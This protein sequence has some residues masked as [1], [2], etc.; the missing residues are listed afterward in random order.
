MPSRITIYYILLLVKL[1]IYILQYFIYYNKRIFLTIP[2]FTS[3]Y[4]ATRF[5][6][7]TSRMR[8]RYLCT[9]RLVNLATLFGHASKEKTIC[10]PPESNPFPNNPNGSCHHVK[11]RCVRNVTTVKAIWLRWASVCNV[12]YIIDRHTLTAGISSCVSYC[13][14]DC[15]PDT[16]VDGI[17]NS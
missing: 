15:G 2:Y 10:L 1:V 8:P 17:I 6:R 3:E 13:N 5:N 4:L 9:V 14:G 7:L 16:A 11:L 12:H